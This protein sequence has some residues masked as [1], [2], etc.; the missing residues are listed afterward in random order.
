MADEPLEAGL[1]GIALSDS[2]SSD[3]EICSTPH[4]TTTTTTTNGPASRAD[5]TALSEEAFQSLK[6]TYTP[7]LENGEIWA[8][9]SLPVSAS[10]NKPEAQELAH[11][12]EELYFLRRW[13]EAVAF[14]QR[15]MAPGT[16]EGETRLDEG[17]K[18]LLRHY[19]S[20]CRERA[21]GK[22]ATQGGQGLALGA[23]TE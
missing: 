7:K 3:A 15:V 23:E 13:D 19:E 1:L 14:I 4:P 5:R 6:A 22:S 11:A 16:G 9:I 2:E 10:V 20:R 18:Q 17:T 21:S 12:V 8:T